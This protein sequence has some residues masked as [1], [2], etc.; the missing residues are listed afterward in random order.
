MRVFQEVDVTSS[1]DEQRPRRVGVPASSGSALVDLLAPDFDDQPR[2]VHLTILDEALAQGRR[3]GPAKT[4]QEVWVEDGSLVGG[5]WE[6][7]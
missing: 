4:V 1:D 7:I 6:K 5:H 3:S 2:S